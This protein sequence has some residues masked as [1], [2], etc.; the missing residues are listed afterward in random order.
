MQRNPNNVIREMSLSCSWGCPRR[1]LDPWAGGETH[2]RELMGEGPGSPYGL[3][4]GFLVWG[5]GR[6]AGGKHRGMVE[7]LR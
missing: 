7:N 1:A 2:H 4:G 5:S 6:D 3:K